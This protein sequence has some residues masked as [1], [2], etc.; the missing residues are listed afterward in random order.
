VWDSL[1][2]AEYLSERL[3]GSQLWPADLPAR[4]R[5]RCV[6]AEMHSG[7]EALRTHFP[8]NLE[9]CAPSIGPRVL[10]EQAQARADL[11][12]IDQLWSDALAQ[13]GGPWLFGALGIA[14]AYFAPV[15]TRIRSYGLPVSQVSAGYVAR[16]FELPALQAW[17]NAA[18]A[19]HDFVPEGEPYRA[20]R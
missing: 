6:C 18:L 11:A 17:V 15:A 8:M 16:I 12:R 9:L 19:E 13:S 3:P 20:A 5:A 10:G 1:A 14:D 7:F 4:A 2:I